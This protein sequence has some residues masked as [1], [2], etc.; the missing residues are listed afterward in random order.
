MVFDTQEFKKEQD[1]LKKFWKEFPK[2]W[3]IHPHYDE[4]YHIFNTQILYFTQE[5]LNYFKVRYIFFNGLNLCY[6]E[7]NKQ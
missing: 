7:K 4:Y 5:L 2:K 1:T 6:K 3:F